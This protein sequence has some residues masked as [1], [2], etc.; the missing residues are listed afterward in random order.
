MSLL[1]CLDRLTLYLALYENKPGTYRRITDLSQLDTI[2]C[3]ALSRIEQRG[4]SDVTLQTSF[5]EMTSM[6]CSSRSGVF[7]NHH[8]IPILEK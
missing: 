1:K 2:V 4:S 7:Y 6:R 3:L 5:C 8:V